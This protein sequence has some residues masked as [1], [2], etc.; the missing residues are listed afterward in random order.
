[1]DCDTGHVKNASECSNSF[2]LRHSASCSSDSRVYN[3]QQPWGVGMRIRCLWR[4][5]GIAAVTIS[6]GSSMT[7]LGQFK[8]AANCPVKESDQWVKPACIVRVRNGLLFVPRKYLKQQEFNQYGLT[9]LW[10][11]SFG[12]LYVN[13]KGRVVIRDVALI[14]NGPDDFHH[15]LVRVLRSGQYG[16]ADPTGRIV[17]PVKY[18]CAIN[19]KDQYSVI[20]PLV[21]VGCRIEK[22]GEY[23]ACLDAKWFR[24]DL[25]GNLTPVKSPL[26]SDHPAN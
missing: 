16:Y 23:T 13:R 18:S 8:R 7:V 9:A 15:G 3:S 4:F 17:V 19:F 2:I 26:E 12:P 25:N 21:C 24:T 11:E 20:G 10:V 1:M 22:E 6:L 14:D 5:L